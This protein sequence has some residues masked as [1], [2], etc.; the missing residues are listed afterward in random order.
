M[1]FATLL[2][3]SLLAAPQVRALTDEEKKAQFLKSRQEADKADETPAP[4]HKKHAAAS[5]SPHHHHA[6]EPKETPAHKHHHA[7]PAPEETPTPARHA[8]RAG[9][10]S[11]PRHKPSP[12][13]PLITYP[14]DTP[15]PART[16]LAAPAYIPPPPVVRTPA[17][18]P[19]PT[20]APTPSRG[21]ADAQVDIRKEGLEQQGGFEPPPPQP[22]SHHHWWQVFSGSEPVH[23][24]FLTKAIRDALDRAP[25]AKRRWR[26]IVVHNCGTRQGNAKI[27]DYYHLHVRKM[28]NGLAYHFVIGNGTSSGNGQI[29]IG[30]RWTRQINGGHVHSDYL[31]NISLGI[32][33]VGDFNRDLPTNEQLAALDEFIRYLRKRVGKIDRKEAIV[34][35]HKEINPPCRPIVPATASPTAGC[36]A[37]LVEAR[38]ALPRWTVSPRPPNLAAAIPMQ[39]HE[40]KHLHFLGI[41]GTAMGAVAAALR[42]RGFTVTGSDENVYPPMS[43]FLQE[44][45]VEIFSGYREENIPA[46]A[47]LIV[48]G[49]AVKRGNPEVEAVLNRR[50]YYLSLPDTLKEFFLRAS[51]NLVVTGTHGKTTTTSLL[52][53]ILEVAG[54]EPSYLIGGIPEKP[55][56]GA[57]F[58][59]SQHFV[60]EGDE[61]D[62][63]FFDKRSKFVH[64]LPELVIVN[65]IEFDHADIFNNLDEIK[66]SFRRLLNIVPG[67]G[68]VLLNGDD[69]NCIDVGKTC[70]APIVEVG[71][72]KNAAN[73][74]EEARCD[75]EGSS[76]RLFGAEFHLPL[77]GMFNIHNAAM[78]ISAAR[79]YGV[80]L[81]TIQRAV[82]GFEGVKR[83]QEVRGEKNGIKVID[84]FGHH[85][86]AIRETLSGLRHQYPGGRLWAVFE[87][88]S[89]TT[90]R[91]IFQHQLPQAF[92]LADGVVLAKVARLEQL[93]VDDRLDPEQVVADIAASRPARLLRA[94]RGGDHLA[95]EIAGA[96]GRHHCHL[97]QR[98]IRRHPCPAAGRTLRLADA[99]PVFRESECAPVP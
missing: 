84:D 17:P 7:T 56:P 73:R 94:G 76:F 27:F 3:V 67:N 8:H 90:R 71:F 70:P 21:G 85:P 12:T 39:P 35:A 80:P 54:L 95:P 77:S 6:A 37:G 47:D 4:H 40:I 89:N 10:E 16:P 93:P 18:V 59:D 97:Q 69:P 30:N 33:L 24:R 48:I 5:P 1:L 19:Q 15:A 72:S 62:T 57:C 26:Y 79:F 34:K 51:H 64:Y 31:N 58:R 49:N 9:S 75:A 50:L 82:A 23:Y 91:A 41:C 20:P 92:D 11:T 86:T 29:E 53:W 65:N 25:V 44:K 99:A 61:Y 52:A 38:I 98:R 88:R 28:P 2:L 55:G 45:G 22:P 36:T 66:L 43:T 14:E 83:R 81:E 68:M 46:E 32:C 78:A 87:P 63:A 74:I 96:G 13:P 42:E 60:L